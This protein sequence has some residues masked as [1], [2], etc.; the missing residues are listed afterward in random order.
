MHLLQFRQYGVV[1]RLERLFLAAVE[2]MGYSLE[3]PAWRR[4]LLVPKAPTFGTFGGSRQ[5][6]SPKSRKTLGGGK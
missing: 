5:T 1:F 2:R 6:G 3:A 4:L